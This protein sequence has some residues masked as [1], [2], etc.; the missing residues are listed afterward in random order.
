MTDGISAAEYA[1]RRARLS[2]HVRALGGA[3]YV[4]SHPTYITYLTGF[5]FLSTERPT[6]YLQNAAGDDA[7]FVAG[8]DVERA[9]AE[10]DFDRIES[11][12]EYPG[13]EH[14]MLILA[15]V[16]A[17]LGLR[18][19]IAADHD[20]YPGILGYI[21]PKLSEVTGAEV[22]DIAPQ[23]ETMLARKSPAEVELLRESGRWCS[24]A[25]R[26]LQQYSVPGRTEAE[27]CGDA[28]QNPHRV[29]ETGVLRVGLDALEVRF[30]PCAFELEPGDE[31]H[32]VTCR[33]LEIHGRTLGR[34][35]PE[36]GE[37]GDVSR[38]TD[39]VARGA[40]RPYVFPQACT[41]VG[42]LGG[43]DRVSHFVPPFTYARTRRV[44]RS[45]L[46]RP[47]FRHAY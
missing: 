46:M 24:Y 42:V 12:P 5:R 20:G 19:T 8:F 27:A 47:G 25:H 10:A 23:I 6:I 9:R 2:D 26:L 15:R 41:T 11:Y 43:R 31:D 14:P 1:D 16:A 34:Q 35:E 30:G 32:L 4:V 21:G 22:I 36:S 3:G 38:V 28:G 39:H 18:Q 29:L 13:L 45:P 37:V 40:E 33:V 17:D 44:R 7:I